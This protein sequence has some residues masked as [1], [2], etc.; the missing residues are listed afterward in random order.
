MEFTTQLELQ[1]Q[2]TRLVEGGLT[3]CHHRRERGCHP[4]R[5]VIPDNFIDDNH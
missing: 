1:S 2:T 5:R 3:S 4:P